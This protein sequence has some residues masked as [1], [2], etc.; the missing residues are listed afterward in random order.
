VKGTDAL[1]KLIFCW[2]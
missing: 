1:Q 2:L